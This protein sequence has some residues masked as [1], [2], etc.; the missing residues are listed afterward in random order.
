VEWAICLWLKSL[1]IKLEFEKIDDCIEW[2]FIFS[3]VIGSRILSFF[4]PSGGNPIL[5]CLSLFV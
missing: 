3:L 4:N 2:S 1:F 5:I